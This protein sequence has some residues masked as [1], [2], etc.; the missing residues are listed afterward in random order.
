MNKRKRETNIREEPMIIDEMGDGE[1]PGP[2]K[3]SS[4]HCNRNV[5]PVEKLIAFGKTLQSLHVEIMS[6]CEVKDCERDRGGELGEEFNQNQTLMRQAFS[7]LAYSDPHNSPLS[8]LLHPSQRESICSSVNSTILKAQ[9]MPE[10]PVLDVV[11]GQAR[12]CLKLMGSNGLAA[13]AMVKVE[14]FYVDR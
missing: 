10:K 12:A 8:Y 3:I 13:S 7:L 2:S 1:C 4:S 11:V 14:D 5:I 6:K 9:N